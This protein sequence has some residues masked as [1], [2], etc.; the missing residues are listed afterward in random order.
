MARTKR[1]PFG[2]STP[3]TSST[4]GAK[5]PRLAGVSE[6]RLEKQEVVEQPAYVP[7]RVESW[8]GVRPPNE[9]LLNTLKFLPY[10]S[11]ARCEA[12]CD[13]FSHIISENRAQL[14]LHSIDC[15]KLD[16]TINP[17]GKVENKRTNSYYEVEKEPG[18]CFEACSSHWPKRQQKQLV[19]KLIAIDE[20]VMPNSVQFVMGVKQVIEFRE[21][22][23]DRYRN[24]RPIPLSLLLFQATTQWATRRGRDWAVSSTSMGAIRCLGSSCPTCCTTFTTSDI[25]MSSSAAS[26]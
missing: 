3:S 24:D 7:P 21:S 11:L 26:S 6:K 19:G 14:P 8:Q 2:S 9:V 23:T 20:D 10:T 25:H 22:Y 12:T 13:E 18:H 4:P 16:W 5:K 1:P 17:Y 15:A